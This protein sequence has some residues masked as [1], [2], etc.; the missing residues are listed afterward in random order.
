MRRLLLPCLALLALS[1]PA[2]AQT[3]PRAFQQ[4][5]L[6]ADWASRTNRGTG[7]RVGVMDGTIELSHPA[8]A[9]TR[10]QGGILGWTGDTARAAWGRPMANCSHG[11][12]VASALVGSNPA[13]GILGVVPEADFYF[14]SISEGGSQS[15]CQNPSWV[16]MTAA[17]QY[18]E[19]QHLDVVVLPYNWPE[20]FQTDVWRQTTRDALASLVAHGTVVVVGA[21]NTTTGVE[22]YPSAYQAGLLVV[23]MV[24][25]LN[26]RFASGGEW[27]PWVD[28][29][30]SVPVRVALPGGLA[31]D[32][33]GT[34][35]AAPLIG[36]LAAL[37]RQA[38]PT[39]T[40]DQVTAR[41]VATGAPLRGFPG[42][43]ANAARFLANVPAASD[44]LNLTLD[45]VATI[46]L[47]PGALTNDCFRVRATVTGLAG[48]ATPIGW[49]TLPTF[50]TLPNKH[51][52]LISGTG[53]GLGLD[54][55]TACAQFA[56]P[57]TALGN[58]TD[59]ITASIGSVTASATLTVSLEAAPT[60]ALSATARAVSVRIDSLDT[61]TSD[62]VQVTLAGLMSDTLHWNA[63][64]TGP[65]TGS[66]TS[67]TTTAWLHYAPSLPSL[68][69]GVHTVTWT[70][71]STPG[72]LAP[73]TATPSA[74]LIETITVR[75]LPAEPPAWTVAAD[76]LLGGASLAADQQAALDALGNQNGNFDLGDVLSAMERAGIITS[77]APRTLATVAATLTR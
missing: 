67:G 37:A 19:A 33:F 14:L 57:G 27:G 72:G 75:A 31:G 43:I 47:M 46:R 55:M 52:W 35:L 4:L 69:V 8:F 61:M 49:S 7:V 28:I 53:G 13:Q 18:A 34:S 9:N 3:L 63:T 68:S 58:Y 6:P 16:S 21:G 5:G 29:F 50:A 2:A 42:T 54:S 39:I 66:A 56:A 40:G 59:E 26:T 10:V 15:E 77:A 60:L 70:V 25:T 76:A 1:S 22:T 12:T 65:S 32:T 71:T 51:Q 41:L 23:G 44:P 45:P 17:L 38:D 62:S 24:D 30:A 73:G 64:G 74:T 20:G 36:G 11:T 48:V